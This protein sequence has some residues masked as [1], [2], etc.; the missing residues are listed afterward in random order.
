MND[1]YQVRTYLQGTSVRSRKPIFNTVKADNA[2]EA[3]EKVRRAI[4][5][6]SPDAIIKK[7]AATPVF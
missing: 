3:K 2:S 7:M 6:D 1:M 5:V 4:L